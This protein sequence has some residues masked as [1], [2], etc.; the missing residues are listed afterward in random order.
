M[1][2]CHV[3]ICPLAQRAYE[4]YVQISLSQTCVMSWWRGSWLWLYGS[5]VRLWKPNYW[6]EKVRLPISFWLSY[7]LYHVVEILHIL[8]DQKMYPLYLEKGQPYA[9]AV[10]S[11]NSSSHYCC[12]NG[13]HSYFNVVICYPPN[14]RV[15]IMDN[16]GI[17]VTR[18]NQESD[19]HK[20]AMSQRESRS[21]QSTRNWVRLPLVSEMTSAI[22]LNMRYY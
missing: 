19:H 10:K 5:A 16:K 2:I 8:I 4:R 22:E 21:I 11:T 7:G 3:R 14:A 15:T 12:E 1:F 20:R 17:Y 6:N 13:E 9:L 18:E